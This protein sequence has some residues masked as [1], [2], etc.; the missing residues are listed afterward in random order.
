MRRY[1][2]CYTCRFWHGF[3]VRERGPKGRCHRFPPTVTSRTPDGSF[4]ISQST[5]W[6]GEWQRET[7]RRDDP[8][9]AMLA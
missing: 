4:P 6:C 7:G 9:E 2:S 5:D 1:D 3:G 8:G